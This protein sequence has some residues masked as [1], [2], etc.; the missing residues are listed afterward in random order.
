[1]FVHQKCI[2]HAL[3]LISLGFV[4]GVVMDMK[5]ENVNLM[6]YAKW[7]NL[8]QQRS[9]KGVVNLGSDDKGVDTKM[10]GGEREQ[11]PSSSYMD[12][13]PKEVLKEVLCYLDL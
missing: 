11:H 3:K 5:G 9:Q 13:M 1:M 2:V 6:M 10:G 12:V 4:R 7:I 8:Q